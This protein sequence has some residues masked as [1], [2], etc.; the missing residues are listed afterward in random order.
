M[1]QARHKFACVGH[2]CTLPD[3]RFLSSQSVSVF[4]CHSVL[5]VCGSLGHRY[6][7]E[8]EIE[9]FKTSIIATSSLRGVDFLCLTGLGCD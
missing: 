6:D 9:Y 3:A 2:L 5:V 8:K 1:A 4:F 7:I